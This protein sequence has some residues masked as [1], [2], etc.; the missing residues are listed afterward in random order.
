MKMSFKKICAFCILIPFTASNLSIT[1][2]YAGST[3]NNPNQNTNKGNST[4]KDHDLKATFSGKE[5]ER[6]R[7]S[8]KGKNNY[9]LLIRSSD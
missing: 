1:T 7:T 9:T 6:V 4:G 2:I 3:G 8:I 5:L